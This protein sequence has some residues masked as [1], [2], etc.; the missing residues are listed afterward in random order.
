MVGCNAEIALRENAYFPQCKAI[1]Y[2]LG[3]YK[4][5]YSENGIYEEVKLFTLVTS[6]DCNICQSL[7]V[8]IFYKFWLC[9]VAG[10]CNGWTCKKNDSI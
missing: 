2:D 5:S 9:W 4:P 6:P 7:N 10:A 3:M 8:K 1:V